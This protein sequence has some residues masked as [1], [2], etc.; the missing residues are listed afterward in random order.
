[1]YIPMPVDTNTNRLIQVQLFEK[2][3][4]ETNAPPIIELRIPPALLNDAAID[5]TLG[6]A[7]SS[8]L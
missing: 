3:M 6:T 5:V 8:T 2:P 7:A 4:P 1:M